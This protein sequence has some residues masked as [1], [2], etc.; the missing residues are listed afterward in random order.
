MA[1]LTHNRKTEIKKFLLLFLPHSLL[2][3]NYELKANLSMKLL[4]CKTLLNVYPNFQHDFWYFKAFK[5]RISRSYKKIAGR[6]FLF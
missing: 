4:P 6:P 2:Q 5:M 3:L 1:T